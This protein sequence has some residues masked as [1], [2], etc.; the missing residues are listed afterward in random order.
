MVE[1][2]EALSVL[3][4][5]EFVVLTAVILLV[6]PFEAAAPLVPLFLIFLFLLYKYRY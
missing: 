6:A 3:I 4:A 5:V 1:S 2:G